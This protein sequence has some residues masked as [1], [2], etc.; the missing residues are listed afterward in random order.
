MRKGYR[1]HNF[2]YKFLRVTFGYIYKAAN[3]YKRIPEKLADPKG[4]F[5]LVSNH[6]MDQDPIWLAMTIKPYMYFVASEHIFNKGLLTKLVRSVFDPI[7]FRKGGSDISSVLD[8]RRRL[9][10]GH[11]ITIFPEGGRNFTGETEKLKPGIGKMVKSFGVN[12]VTFKMRG[13]YLVSPRW[14]GKLRRGKFDGQVVAEY[15]A[16]DLKNMT[17][18]EIDGLIARDIY[19]NDFKW[20]EE[21]GNLYNSSRRAEWIEKSYFVCPKCGSISSIKSKRNTFKCEKCGVTAEYGKDAHIHGEGFPFTD[22]IGWNAYQ[23]KTLDRLVRDPNADYSPFSD[24][25]VIFSQTPQA[26]RRI[27]YGICSVKMDSDSLTL[28]VKIPAKGSDRKQEF[29]FPVSEIMGMSQ[30][31]RNILVFSY[32]SEKYEIKRKKISLRKYEELYNALKRKE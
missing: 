3:G 22:L 27:R 15:P 26:G 9:K 32:K 4:P 31:G 29:V 16:E 5:I 12:L 20:Q 21:S 11:N 19:Q 2:I 7:P 17:A 30:C 14:S 23:E 1:W 6:C 28:I 25:M 8:M 18:E 10:E 13:G 24:D